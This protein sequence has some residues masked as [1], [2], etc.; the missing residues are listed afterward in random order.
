[1]KQYLKQIAGWT[2]KVDNTYF[3]SIEDKI[4]TNQPVT[5]E[6]VGHLLGMAEP[7]YEY[8]KCPVCKNKILQ[9]TLYEGKKTVISDPLW[10]LRGKAHEECYK[11]E[12]KKLEKESRNYD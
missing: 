11:V 10:E 6:V 2:I 4:R 8:I 3:Y 7:R 9:G 5:P 1:M 12:L